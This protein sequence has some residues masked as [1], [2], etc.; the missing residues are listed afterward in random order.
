[1]GAMASNENYIELFLYWPRLMMSEVLE[2]LVV[3]GRL[4]CQS[5]SSEAYRQSGLD[6]K[7][8]VRSCIIGN[9]N[10]QMRAWLLDIC[11]LL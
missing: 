4:K 5:R 6:H 10:D 8:S 1:V 9:E 3:E 11:F 2:C 7:G